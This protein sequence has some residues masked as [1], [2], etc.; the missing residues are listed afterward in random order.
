MG[1]TEECSEIK[2]LQQAMIQYLGDYFLC[3]RKV[4][5]PRR[6][7]SESISFTLAFKWCISLLHSTAVVRVW[8]KLYPGQT[9]GG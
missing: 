8:A 7:H 1:G 3:D 4:K 9:Y 6:I 5:K 2:P